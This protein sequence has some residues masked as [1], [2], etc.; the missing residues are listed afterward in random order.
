VTAL[1]E[2]LGHKNLK[3]T[4]QYTHAS[5]AGKLKVAQAQDKRKVQQVGPKSV[6]NNK[7]QAS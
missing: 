2:T 5:K 6:A 7:R 1:A 4:M 3:T